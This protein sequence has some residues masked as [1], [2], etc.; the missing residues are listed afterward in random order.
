MK[1][2]GPVLSV[3]LKYFL[4]VK[5]SH[6]HNFS[7]LQLD[8]HFRHLSAKANIPI[9]NNGTYRKFHFG[10]VPQAF[11]PMC[12]PNCL[13]FPIEVIDC[14]IESQIQ[15]KQKFNFKINFNFCYRKLEKKALISK[16]YSVL[17]K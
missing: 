7:I 16:E 2:G 4:F 9:A 10:N 12:A 15:K 3:L 14:K 6:L 5:L 17:L 8:H 11:P 13:S 1:E